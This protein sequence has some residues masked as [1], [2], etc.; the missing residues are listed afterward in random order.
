[1]RSRGLWSRLAKHDGVV[2][3][4]EAH[5]VAEHVG[6]SDCFLTSKVHVQS[7]GHAHTEKTARHAKNSS[8]NDWSLNFSKR[9]FHAGNKSVVV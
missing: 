9:G 2:A 6:L 3:L 1:M 8:G 7:A 4:G 5:A